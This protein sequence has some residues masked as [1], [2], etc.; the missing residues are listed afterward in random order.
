MLLGVLLIS[1]FVTM[2]LYGI[3]V[4]QVSNIGV[5]QTRS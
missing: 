1:A 2:G 4:L 3:T 5:V